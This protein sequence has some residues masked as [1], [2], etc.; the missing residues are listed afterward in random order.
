MIEGTGSCKTSVHRLHCVTSQKTSL[1]VFI[2]EQASN[3]TW[4]IFLWEWS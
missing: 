4:Q 2:P 3:L 1:S